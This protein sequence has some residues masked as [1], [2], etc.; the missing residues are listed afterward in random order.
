[1]DKT[2]EKR[3]MPQADSRQKELRGK[4]IAKIHIG[5]KYLGLSDD[6]YRILLKCSTDGM[7]LK[8]AVGEQSTKK[9][10]IG[11]L[12]EVLLSMKAMG[13][14][15]RKKDEQ[16]KYFTVSASDTKKLSDRQVKYIKG[17]W[18]KKAKNPSEETLK[19]F[20]GRLTGKNSL[21]EC[22]QTEANILITALNNMP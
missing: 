17:L 9:M 21:S 22:G 15:Y 1:M 18:W 7:R 2:I 11:E 13:F 8:P 19:V 4:L 20:I 16:K 12:K 6:D 14:D 5:K 3:H 10:T